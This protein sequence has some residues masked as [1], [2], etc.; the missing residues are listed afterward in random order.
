MEYEVYLAFYLKQEQL[1]FVQ[2]A[3]TF[4]K[5]GGYPNKAAFNE[6]NVR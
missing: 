2:S 1:I 5:P 6:I 3:T 4:W